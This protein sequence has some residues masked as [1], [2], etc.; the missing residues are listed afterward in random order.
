MPISNCVDLSLLARTV[1]NARW[2][3]RYDL[4]LGLARLIESY[5]Y[6]ILVKGK[7]TRSNWEAVLSEMQQECWHQFIY[8]RH[9]FNHPADASN[10][11]HAG[12]TLYRKFGTLLPLLPTPPDREWY[13][14][15]LVDGQ[16]Y[17]QDG[18]QWQAENPNYDPGPLPPPKL[19]KEVKASMII[20]ESN[21]DTSN[22]ENRFQR[23]KARRNSKPDQTH[24]PLSTSQQ[25]SA[26]ASGSTQQLRPQGQRSYEYNPQYFPKNSG[27]IIS[28]HRP[29]GAHAGSSAQCRLGIS[30]NIRNDR[31][32][33]TEQV[34]NT[35][36]GYP[37][38]P[39]RRPR[40]PASPTANHS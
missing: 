20:T 16:L 34:Q 35:D 33:S 18:T 22:N 24:L 7:I 39:R 17:K 2:Q 8:F 38:H 10:D 36:R 25:S 27:Q 1:D 6:R 4:P 30:S 40:H 32:Q 14:F 19:P 11:A 9:E 23:R 13:S 15:D 21:G 29:T 31:G 12:F 26:V 5:E 3:G 37:K 28:Q